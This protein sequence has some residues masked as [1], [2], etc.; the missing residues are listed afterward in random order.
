MSL[1]AYHLDRDFI[2]RIYCFNL[3]TL[4]EQTKLYPL[5]LIDRVK[6]EN[7]VIST[8][9]TD[10]IGDQ[11]KG[12]VNLGLIAKKMLLKQAEEI[13]ATSHYLA[14]LT[15]KMAPK[16]KNIHI[17]PFGIDCEQFKRS[18]ENNVRNKFRIGFI[19]HLIKKYGPEYLIK[20]VAEIRKNFD[21]VE[22]IMV[23]HGEMKDD[24]KK[25][26]KNLGIENC[27]KFTGYICNEKIPSILSCLDICVMPS[28]IEAFGVSAI[29]AQAMEVPVVAS[30][31]G[32]IPEVVL[33]GVTGIL[34]EPENI[35]ELKSAIKKLIENPLLRKNMG[36]AGRKFVLKHYNIEEN[37]L[38]FKN[39]Y[40]KIAEE[41]SASTALCNC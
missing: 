33:D 15:A 5:G 3:S 9:G 25:L 13:T 39:L 28:I 24:L 7:L 10:V 1:N 8:W 31:V 2:L 16:N 29:E 23:G 6:F 14:S 4:P 26:A 27:V 19:K 38:L 40:Y 21:N 37:V 30:K 18:N 12:S 35:E 20:S 17:I 11:K 36:K 32:G 34:V 22:L 41:K